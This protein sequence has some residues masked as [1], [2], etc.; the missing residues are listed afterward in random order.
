[1]KAALFWLLAIVGG[2][3]VGAVGGT[4]W[5]VYRG[6]PVPGE[7]TEV[8]ADPVAEAPEDDAEAPAG[9]IVEESPVGDD[10]ADP[11]GLAMAGSDPSAG[12]SVAGGP[13]E[14][15]AGVP[16]SGVESAGP[17]PGA[18]AAGQPAQPSEPSPN[19]QRL[20][21]IFAAMRAEEAASV[22]GQLGDDEIQG[23]LMAMPARNAAPI[24]AE[25]DPARAASLS[26]LVL[27]GRSP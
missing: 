3:A 24:L 2:A 21:R 12:D 20:A 10:G 6:V 18:Q 13:G 11:G 17:D 1:M 7:G 9:A 22:L 5:L 15:L 26:R 16:G 14:G 19:H 23:I 27:G 8:V 4:A 25:L